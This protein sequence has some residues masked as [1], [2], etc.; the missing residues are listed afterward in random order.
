VG[1]RS[2]SPNTNN[3][4]VS[5]LPHRPV[6]DGCA[7]AHS[8]RCGAVGY[9]YKRPRPLRHVDVSGTSDR[10]QPLGPGKPRGH[11]RSVRPKHPL[12][13]QAQT[14]KTGHYFGMCPGPARAYVS[15]LLG[16]NRTLYWGWRTGS[17]HLLQTA[18]AYQTLIT[19]A[20]GGG[21]LRWG[22][23]SRALGHQLLGSSGHGTTTNALRGRVGTCVLGRFGLRHSPVAGP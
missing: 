20:L 1:P 5:E 8:G 4:G 7:V 15:R 14:T 3:N 19:E 17:G 6:M 2:S 12:A 21:L 23:S 22:L 10:A 11:F 9:Y 16:R 18:G 13:T